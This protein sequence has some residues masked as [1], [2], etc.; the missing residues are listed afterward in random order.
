MRPVWDLP[1]FLPMFGKRICLYYRG[2][3][4]KCSN[5]FGPHARR[6]C[7]REKVTWIQYVSDLMKEYPDI[8]DELYGKWATYVHELR[9]KREVPASTEMILDLPPITATTDEPVSLPLNSPQA[10]QGTKADPLKKIPSKPVTEDY[11][12][13]K[14]LVILRGQGINITQAPQVHNDTDTNAAPLPAS[15]KNRN[16]HENGRGRGRRKTSLN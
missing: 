1:Q 2:I 15:T 6:V 10:P 11:N 14:R 8:P 4:K 9:A 12:V 5:C 3:E 13:N 7:N 16:G